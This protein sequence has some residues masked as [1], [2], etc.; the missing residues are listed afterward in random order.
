MNP[1]YKELD[2][3]LDSFKEECKSY[4]REFLSQVEASMGKTISK[5]KDWHSKLDLASKPIPK[6]A[7][8]KI[9]SDEDSE[10]EKDVA[11]PKKR[12]KF[13]HKRSKEPEVQRS[14][15]QKKR[16]V[17]SSDEE[18]YD[19]NKNQN[20]IKITLKKEIETKE[21]QSEKEEDV[22]PLPK[23]ELE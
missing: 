15:P 11:I 19:P 17:E 18:I 6:K 9:S 5:I 4:Q 12:I 22:K 20:L 10:S 14:A 21:S 1:S 2:E 13:T 23:N 3:F 7:K 8:A 16:K